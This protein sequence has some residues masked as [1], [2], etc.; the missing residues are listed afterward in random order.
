MARLTVLSALLSAVVLQAQP[1]VP[2]FLDASPLDLDLVTPHLKAQATGPVRI[3]ADGRAVVT[4]VVTPKPKMHVYAADVEG[5][6]P[7]TL[8]V[9]RG[10]GS[11]QAR[12]PTPPP[13]HT[14]SRR[15]ARR[16]GCT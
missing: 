11:R 8:K 10:R 3:G 1:R 15:P 7:F 12:S 9:S 16:L 13:R 5:Y 4:V 6:M 14:C 2:T